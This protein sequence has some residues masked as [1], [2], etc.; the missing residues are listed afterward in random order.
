MAAMAWAGLMLALAD[1]H[2]ASAQIGAP[3]TQTGRQLQAADGDTVVVDGDD[4][5][6]LVRRRQA[7][8]RVVAD[9]SAST[10]LVIADWGTRE[11][12]Q[13]DGRVNRTWR[14]AGVD[15]RWPLESR[16]EA[17]AVMIVPDRPPMSPG[18]ALSLE[19]SAGVIALPDLQTMP[20]DNGACV[21]S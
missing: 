13:P 8:V 21:K 1:R 17:D 16:W 12:A 5:V 20:R 7:H 18:P 19:T 10:V 11:S 4:R 15:G 2:A 3:I 6:S 14:F 9:E